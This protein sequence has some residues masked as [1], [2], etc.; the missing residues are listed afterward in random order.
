MCP[1]K[2]HA[3]SISPFVSLRSNCAEN[4]RKHILHTGKHEGVKMY[5]CPKC[6]Y[7]TN[8][9]MEF[10]N[11]LKENH[12]DIENPDLAYLHAGKTF[13]IFWLE[14]K[15][16]ALKGAAW[17]CVSDLLLLFS[18]SQLPWNLS[19]KWRNTCQGYSLNIHAHIKKG[20]CIRGSPA[21]CLKAIGASGWFSA[22][23]CLRRLPLPLLRS[24]DGSVE[25]FLSIK[26]NMSLTMLKITSVVI[27][28]NIRLKDW[29]W[30]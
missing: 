1:Q 16:W 2:K 10:R 22:I 23:S 25:L 13:F 28:P 9:P 12:P 30:N 26:T 18:C 11:H 17:C 15:V 20:Q 19:C 4:I 6:N 5:N 8:S 7:A 27:I 24:F 3:P 29:R 14:R 21:S